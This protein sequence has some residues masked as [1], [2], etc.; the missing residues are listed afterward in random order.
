MLKKI[1]IQL[2]GFFI[3]ALGIVGIIYARLGASPIDAF[4]YFVSTTTP[5]TLGTV[6]VLS[7][8]FV[9]LICFI[10]D[11]KWS[12]IFSM[13]FLLSVGIFVDG[14]KFIFDLIPSIWLEQLLIRIPLA[15]ISLLLIAFG[16]SMTIS[17]G[18]M[19][20]P[21]EQLMLIIDR[22]IHHLGLSKMM[23]EGT[24]L[25]FAVMMGIYTKQLWDQVF[26]MTI[27][28]ALVNGPLTHIF[29]NIIKKRKKEEM[30]HET[31]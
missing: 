28:I 12:I 25:I 1:I 9:S 22:K 6:T 13:L 15:I 8:F 21:Y 10:V 29:V 2:T 19:M 17:T 11:K 4:N 30:L 16:V 27:V 5:L 26:V 18:L 31:K 7:G 23:I 24:F 3:C 20:A 14:W